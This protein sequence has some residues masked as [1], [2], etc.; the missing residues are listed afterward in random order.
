MYMAPGVSYNGQ[1]RGSSKGWARLN[2]IIKLY[3]YVRTTGG[4]IRDAYWFAAPI[5]VHCRRATTDQEQKTLRIN[6]IF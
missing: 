2:F 4:S 1:Q 3:D 5:H 6:P